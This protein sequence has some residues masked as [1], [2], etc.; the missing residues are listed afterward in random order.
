M[1]K[2]ELNPDNFKVLKK[3]LEKHYNLSSTNIAKAHFIFEQVLYVM[4][5]E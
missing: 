5:N 2:V 4:V 1:Q 3:A